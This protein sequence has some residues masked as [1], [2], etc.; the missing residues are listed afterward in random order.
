MEQIFR[1]DER[2]E[3][4]VEA[5]IKYAEIAMK[6]NFLETYTLD[7]LRDQ[8]LAFQSFVKKSKDEWCD[9]CNFSKKSEFERKLYNK[10]LH[11]PSTFPEVNHLLASATVRLANESQCEAMGSVVG[12]YYEYRGSLKVEKISKETFISWNGPPPF[13]QSNALLEDALQLRFG[14]GPET[15][16]FLRL[17]RRPDKLKTY[18]HGS[19]KVV[20][21]L[22]GLRSRIDYNDY[23][24]K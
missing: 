5:F 14:G 11:N 2:S 19:S 21:R 23:F 8:Y 4:G 24:T 12:S 18:L 17:T 20:D 6:A 10:L 1:R 9:S 3:E 16:N 22:N 15:W 13:E 7:E